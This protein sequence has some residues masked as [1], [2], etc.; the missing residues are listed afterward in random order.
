MDGRT[1]LKR[2]DAY[3]EEALFLRDENRFLRG[4]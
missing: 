1:L 4:D 2:Y 3:K